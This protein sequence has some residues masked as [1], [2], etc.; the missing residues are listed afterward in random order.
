MWA[1]NAWDELP[2]GGRI[3]P[4]RRPAHRKCKSCRIHDQGPGAK[5]LSEAVHIGLRAKDKLDGI[6][7]GFLA[8]A[9][10]DTP[11]V[12]VI[13]GFLGNRAVVV[14]HPHVG[15]KLLHP[16]KPL[17]ARDRVIRKRTD[18]YRQLITEARSRPA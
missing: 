10:P 16:R 5:L 18:E 1:N 17:L 7:V 15:Q 3:L 12:R 2:D 14:N 6:R 8:D 4:N 9:L 13:A 11:E